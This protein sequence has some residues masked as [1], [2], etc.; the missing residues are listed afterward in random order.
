MAATQIVDHRKMLK[1]EIKKDARY[2]RLQEAFENLAEYQLPLEEM[3]KEILTTHKTRSIRRL[4]TRANDFIDKVIE[5]AAG[6]INARGRLTEI[7]VAAL[8]ASRSLKLA[9]ETLSDYIVS[10]YGD[11]L[12]RV[13]ST[14]GERDK[15]IEGILRQFINYTAKTDCL[16]EAAVLVITDIDKDGYG[17]RIIVDTMRIHNKPESQL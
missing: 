6:D 1:A 4:N 16:R 5:A 12:R 14:K 11:K 10:K 7:M 9:I 13:A 3:H 8:K 17:L 15:F 2:I